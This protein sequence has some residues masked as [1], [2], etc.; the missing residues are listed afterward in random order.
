MLFG[1][2]FSVKARL[3]CFFAGISFFRNGPAAGAGPS[4]AWPCLFRCSRVH[5]GRAAQQDGRM[6]RPPWKRV[7]SG[8]SV[9]Y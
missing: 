2:Q 1:A 8:G 7:A 4:A 5:R 9:R 3:L 6:V